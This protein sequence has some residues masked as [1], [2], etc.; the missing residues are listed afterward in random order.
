MKILYKSNSTVV[1]AA[2][3]IKMSAVDYIE[4]IPYTC[5]LGVD[6]E[7]VSSD[8]YEI[9][10]WTDEVSFNS[11]S[12]NVCMFIHVD[13]G[14]KTV[15]QWGDIESEDELKYAKQK[16]LN[17]LTSPTDSEIDLFE[18]QLD[19][20]FSNLAENLDDW[21]ENYGDPIDLTGFVDDILTGYDDLDYDTCYEE[22]ADIFDR[23]SVRYE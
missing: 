22:V 21:Y 16:I 15:A 5:E 20:M 13:K 8:G 2:T 11:W 17:A 6:K 23:Y 12:S 19:D 18:E 3:N 1:S 4:S 10:V 14:D 7:Y 9:S